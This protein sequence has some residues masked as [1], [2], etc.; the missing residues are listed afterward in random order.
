MPAKRDT[1]FNERLVGTIILCG[2]GL[3]YALTRQAVFT[4][5]GRPDDPVNKRHPIYVNAAGLDAIAI[6]SFFIGL[7]IINLA[8]GIRGPRR[9][10][11]FWTGAGLLIAAVLYGLTQA[12]MAVVTLFR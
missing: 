2:I 3:W 5:G 9:L 4:I 11:V 10:P 7:G 8:L 1:R 12:V 6:G